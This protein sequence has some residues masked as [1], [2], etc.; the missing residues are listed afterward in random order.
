MPD[1]TR[2]EIPTI[3]NRRLGYLARIIKPVMSL[4]TRPYGRWPEEEVNTYH[5]CMP[6]NLREGNLRAQRVTGGPLRLSKV[7]KITT[8]HQL[9]SRGFWPTVA[10]V[11]AQI[12]DDLLRKDVPSGNRLIAFETFLEGPDPEFTPD[13]RFYKAT[14]IL[15]TKGKP[16][17]GTFRTFHG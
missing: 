14:T 17:A 3:S 9:D 10:E 8:L 7:A 16:A 2:V 12:P 6:E 4:T 15:L 5:L 13:D 11:L 1:T